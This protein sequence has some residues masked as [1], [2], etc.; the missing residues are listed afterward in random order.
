MSSKAIDN[1]FLSPPDKFSIS[2]YLALE[3]RSILRISSIYYITNIV[4]LY[5][6]INDIVFVF[7][8]LH[9]Y[10]YPL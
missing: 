9:I 6:L 4:K 5:F 7:V 10:V 3:S 1:R 8:L 2:V